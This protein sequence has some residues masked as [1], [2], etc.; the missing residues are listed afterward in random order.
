MESENN[1]VACLPSWLERYAFYDEDRARAYDAVSPQLR[2]MLKKTVARLHSIYGTLPRN[3]VAEQSFDAFT[4]RQTRQPV[5]CVFVCVQEKY[6][7]PQCFMATLIPPLLAGVE[8]IVPLFIT[9]ESALAP[10]P[11]ES[12]EGSVNGQSAPFA[13]SAEAQNALLASLDLAG[14]EQAYLLPVSECHDAIAEFFATLSGKSVGEAGQHAAASGPV[15]L[16]GA[17]KMVLLGSFPGWETLAL[18]AARL[19]IPCTVLAQEPRY[20]P[21]ESPATTQTSSGPSASCPQFLPCLDAENHDV[22]LWPGLEPESFCAS[23]FSVSKPY[24]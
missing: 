3:L 8:L 16:Y 4:L 11:Q 5:S 7:Y 20:L 19:G 13:S 24:R 10:L 14:V 15:S 1:V 12:L 17:G 23:G 9:G 6:L 21:L 22:W 18:L 2:A